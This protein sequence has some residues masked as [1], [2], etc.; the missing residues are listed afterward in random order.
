MAEKNDSNTLVNNPAGKPT[1]ADTLTDTESITMPNVKNTKDDTKKTATTK[2]HSLLTI[3]E[4]IWL[5]GMCLF[6]GRIG[7]SY[8]VFRKQAKR[9]SL[10]A[11][12]M[13]Q[14][15]LQQV[16]QQY[17]IRRKIRLQRNNKI[18]SPMLYGIIKPS[19][20]LPDEKYSP[21]EYQYIFRHELSHYRHGDIWN[22]YAMNL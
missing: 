6:F 19:I 7:I 9:W 18:N 13:T 3:A 11:D 12:N 8:L 22:S 21:Q 15:I 2:L 5:L 20:L 16:Q 10:P 1:A 14:Q 4:I 17:G